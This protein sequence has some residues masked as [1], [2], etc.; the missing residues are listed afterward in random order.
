MKKGTCEN[1]HTIFFIWCDSVTKSDGTVTVSQMHLLQIP[2]LL[3]DNSLTMSGPSRHKRSFSFLFIKGKRKPMRICSMNKH[4]WLT[5][6]WVGCYY[7]SAIT[8]MSRYYSGSS[9]L[10]DIPRQNSSTLS[11]TKINV[12]VINMI[13]MLCKLL[14]CN[15]CFWSKNG[16]TWCYLCTRFWVWIP[17]LIKMCIKYTLWIKVSPKLINVNNVTSNAAFFSRRFFFKLQ[18]TVALLFYSPSCACAYYV[19]L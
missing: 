19:L 7:I 4:K 18:F 3:Q 13:K 5:F 10:E 16:R 17:V 9:S 15:A 14:T 6:T 11:K 1:D 12:S 2:R 8:S